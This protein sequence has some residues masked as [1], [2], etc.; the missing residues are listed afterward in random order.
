MAELATIAR[1]YAE[2]LFKAVGAADA[3][4]DG[5]KFREPEIPTPGD[6]DDISLEQT[7]GDVDDPTR[8]GVE[9]HRGAQP[10]LSLRA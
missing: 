2:A 4:L 10:A 8:G 1:P 9:L 6:G 7:V 3:P 5:L